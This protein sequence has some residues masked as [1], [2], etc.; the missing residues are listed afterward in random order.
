MYQHIWCFL[1]SI[2]A[3]FDS[4]LL[5]EQMIK[6]LEKAARLIGI[7]PFEQTTINHEKV[8]QPWRSKTEVPMD[9]RN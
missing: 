7:C 2:N 5:L 6:I 3:Q 8:G 9:V 1:Y 4:N